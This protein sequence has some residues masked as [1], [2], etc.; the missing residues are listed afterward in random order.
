[1]DTGQDRTTRFRKQAVPAVLFFALVGLMFIDRPNWAVSP[2]A[3]VWTRLEVPKDHNFAVSIESPLS[4][5]RGGYLLVS[6][7]AVA[8]TPVVRVA[9]IEVYV[10]GVLA[11]TTADF[12]ARPDIAANFG[13]ADAEMSGWQCVV[14]MG[15]RSAGQHELLLNVI[16]SDGK[17]ELAVTRSLTIVE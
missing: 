8:A 16:G 4:A 13:R 7:W 1:M 5:Q 17:R 15:A 2:P 14:A 10:D 12:L 3:R 6:G 11:G 9:T